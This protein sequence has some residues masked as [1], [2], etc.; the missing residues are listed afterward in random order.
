M[1]YY[2]KAIEIITDG[3]KEINWYNICVEIAK[4]NPKK[5]VDAYTEVYES[6]N[7]WMKDVKNLIKEQRNIQAIK[8]YREKTG[9]DLRTAKEAVDDIAKSMPC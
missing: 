6:E 9:T 8:L 1:N 7:K 3:E 4:N 5:L 2:K